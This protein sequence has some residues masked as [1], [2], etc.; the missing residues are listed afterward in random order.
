MLRVS[1]PAHRRP[2]HGL[3]PVTAPRYDALALYGALAVTFAETHPFCDQIVQSSDDAIAK[4]KPGT[5]GR[6]ACAR[7]V[8]TYTLGQTA[9]AYTVTRTLGYQLPLRAYLAGAAINAATHY[10]IDRRTPL[11]R[12]LRHPWIGKAHYLDHATC[13]RR[14]GTVDESGPG[15]A[16]YEMD[17]AAHRVIGV[18]AAAVTAW[19]AIRTGT[20]AR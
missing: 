17:Q 12:F 2:L 3:Q 7:H 6:R 19:L 16:L 8:A 11:L 4:G 20:A 9:A 15:T 18:A 14:P 10:V 13:Q 5:E 1:G